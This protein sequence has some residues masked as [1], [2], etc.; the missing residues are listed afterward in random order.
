MGKHKTA[1]SNAASYQMSA[2]GCSRFV[3]RVGALAVALGVGIA[4]ATAPGVAVA[5]TEDDPGTGAEPTQPD[6][7]P[8]DNT[9]DDEPVADDSEDDAEA[10]DPPADEIDDEELPPG[11]GDETG[12]IVEPGSDAP[13][14]E[15]PTPIPSPVIAPPAE[16]DPQAGNDEVV[17]QAPPEA[18]VVTPHDVPTPAAQPEAT[19]EISQPISAD[20]PAAVILAE[21]SIQAPAP[22]TT[23]EEQP[24]PTQSGRLSPINTAPLQPISSALAAPVAIVTTV[25]GALLAPLLAP[26]GPA[27]P[28]Q[29][30]IL[31]AVLAWVRRQFEH[32]F[33]NKAPVLVNNNDTELVDP[34]TVTGSVTAHDPDPEDR[35]VLTYSGG[36]PHAVI[37]VAPGGQWTY[38]APSDWD[39][40]TTHTDSFTIAATEYRGGLL[41][42]LA[43]RGRTATTQVTVSIAP[44][45]QAPVAVDDSDTTLEDTD[46]TG[47]V[48]A[49]DTDIDTPASGLSVTTSTVTTD[50]GGTITFDPDGH[51]TYTPPTDFAGYDTVDYTVTD[52]F[53]TDTAE[54]AITVL[55]DAVITAIPIP[56]GATSVSAVLGVDGTATQ[57]TT[58]GDGSAD[59]P[60]YTQVTVVSPDGTV[61][62]TAPVPGRPVEMEF[63]PTGDVVVGADGTVAQ[64]VRSGAGSAADPH[65]TRMIVVAPDGA[66]TVTD[67]I[68]GTPF[69]GAVVS[70]N[71]TA[72][73][74]TYSGAGTTADPYYTRLTVVAA[75]GTVTRTDPISGRPVPTSDEPTRAAVVGSDGTAAV[76]TR[77][78]S[79][80][81]VTAI[82][83]DGRVT[84]TDPVTAA[85]STWAGG[86]PGEA[87][88]LVG[89]DGTTA[90]TVFTGSGA[91]ADPYGVRVIVIAPDGSVT[92]TDP[93]TGFPIGSV[94]VGADGTVAQTAHS[95]S[96]SA[97]DPS[98]TRV[99][100]VAPDGT[101]TTTSIAGTS[102]STDPVVAA[103]GT[104]YQP[105]L[106]ETGSAADPFRTRVITVAPDGTVTTTDPI[107]GSPSGNTVVRADGTA[108]QTTSATSDTGTVTRIAAIA[109][110]GTVT[111]TDPIP[112]NPVGG[113]ALGPDGTLAQ[114]TYTGSGHNTAM[115]VIVISPDGLVTTT[116][117]TPG[118]LATGSVVI[119]PD[120]TAYHTTTSRDLSAA[121]LDLTRVTVIAPDGAVTTTD[122][123]PGYPTHHA[124]LSPDGTLYQATNTGYGSLSD[125]YEIVV[126][127]IAPDGTIVSTSEPIPGYPTRPL[128]VG[129]D[130]TAYLL[131]AEYPGHNGPYDLVT[132]TPATVRV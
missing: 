106:I 20:Q 70:A 50:R 61:A 4:M 6:P 130:G 26:S 98:Y 53:S 77:T 31:W 49:N 13:A 34:D 68:V 95:G 88:L 129:A 33:A 29:T 18:P 45:N 127:A 24:Q 19:P 43:P 65:Q 109:P 9:L 118:R 60:Y 25:L 48:L 22:T 73:Q 8:E 62:T 23:A 113:P 90:Y 78:G 38:T 2:K 115:R 58:T 37:G 47:N 51:Y 59:N 117:P 107:P 1:S 40:T 15:P 71:G 112:G 64:T 114:V 3:G 7:E 94:A 104:T 116:D 92:T 14:T 69:L 105:I 75:D 42:L 87:A 74:S 44:T 100:V 124:V 101:V 17:S 79:Q 123:I 11:D 5:E 103:D 82:A 126:T 21:R 119:A 97:S 16:I 32:T 63:L 72:A 125:P 111:T 55:D 89:A 110:D 46:A 99:I 39:G 85:Q 57:T 86:S 122:P 12:V 132:V 27:T 80:L 35:V 56:D 93:V 120:G 41:G 131:V 81:R 96:G 91:A 102:P 108:F 66:V 36:D 52:G 128:V 54:L 28:A 121:V 84:T 10:E 76:V 30:P 83:P 67:P